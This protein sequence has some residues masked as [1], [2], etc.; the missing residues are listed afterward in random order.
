MLTIIDVPCAEGTSKVDS[1]LGLGNH[2]LMEGLH[3]AHWYDNCKDNKG[4]DS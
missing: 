2:I 4:P 1:W 3:Q